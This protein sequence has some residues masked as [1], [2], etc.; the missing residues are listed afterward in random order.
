MHPLHSPSPSSSATSLDVTTTLHRRNNDT[1]SPLP[2]PLL[3]LT[4]LVRRDDNNNDYA[5]SPP[6]LTSSS[7]TSQ[8]PMATLLSLP[9]PCPRLPRETQ[10]QHALSLPL[11]LPCLTHLVRCDLDDSTCS[12]LSLP[13]PLSS[14]P[15]PRDKT[16]MTTMHALPSHFLSL[17][18]IHLARPNVNNK[19]V[20]PPSPSPSPS[21]TS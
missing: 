12:P 2:L 9:L 5:R 16:T 4:H 8:D 14:S 6:A 15:T 19:C 7:P 3:V 10:R 13:L 18:L 17:V 21:P 11:P 20:L 1:H